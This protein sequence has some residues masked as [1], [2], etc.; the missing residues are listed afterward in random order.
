MNNLG[1]KIGIA[2]LSDWYELE[3]AEYGQGARF[4]FNVYARRPL[5]QSK[6]CRRYPNTTKLFSSVYPYFKWEPWRFKQVHTF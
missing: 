5:A 3:F 4:L 6:G 1:E 2:T